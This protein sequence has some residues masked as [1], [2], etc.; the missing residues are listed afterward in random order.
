MT[1]KD[2]RRR[3]KSPAK[4]LRDQKV[5]EMAV[6]GHSINEIAETV[7][8]E[9]NQVSRILSDEETAELVR[10]LEDQIKRL[11][12]EAV[13]TLMDAMAMRTEHQMMGH[14]VKAAEKVLKSIGALKERVDVN[15]TSDEPWIIQ[16]SDGSRMVLGVGKKPEGEK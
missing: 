5:R 16:M 10:A 15:H 4:A 3:K 9:R 1:E 2:A 6:T 11:G 13:R 7:G 12:T 14:A 8:L